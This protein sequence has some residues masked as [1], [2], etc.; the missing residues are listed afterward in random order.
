MLGDK[1]GGEKGKVTGR[2]VLA[3]PGGNATMETSFEATGTMLGVK[4]RSR[5]TY[6]ASLRPD[7]TL[8]GEGNGIVMGDGGELATWTGQGVGVIGKNGAVSFRGAVYYQSASPKWARLNTVAAV[9]EYDVDAQGN[10]KS[11]LWEWK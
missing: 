5:T 1:I 2:R 6:T 4:E 11:Q 9:F 10:T 3:N 8:Y 7:G